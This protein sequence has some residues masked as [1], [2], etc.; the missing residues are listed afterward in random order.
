M[1][2]VEVNFNRSISTGTL[3]LSVCIDLYLIRIM[4]HQPAALLTRISENKSVMSSML[5]RL[6]HESAG[7][8]NR[9]DDFL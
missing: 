4:K 8:L 9:P 7:L 2:R 1:Q 6:Q 3:D 5:N